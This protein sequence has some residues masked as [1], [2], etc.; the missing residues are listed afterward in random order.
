M[1]SSCSSATP[2]ELGGA[3]ETMRW[4]RY[5]PV[6]GGRSTA[7]YRARSACVMSP[8][9]RD[10]SAAIEIGNPPAVERVGPVLGNV[11]ERGCEIGL[12]QPLAGRARAS[13]PA[14]ETCE[15]WTGTATDSA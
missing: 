11:L 7:A 15:R 12:H 5:V 1:F 6:S 8:P 14:A 10:I 3:I 4:P 2:P 9:V 13:R